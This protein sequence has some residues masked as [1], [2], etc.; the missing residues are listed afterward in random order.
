[1]EKSIKNRLLFNSFFVMLY[2]QF[3]YAIK[4]YS[5]IPYSDGEYLQ[6]TNRFGQKVFHIK[7]ANNKTEQYK[8]E[9]CHRQK[10]KSLSLFE[11][12]LEF[13]LIDVDDYTLLKDKIFDYRNDYVHE[14]CNFVLLGQVSEEEIKIM[15]DLKKISIKAHNRA[16]SFLD[17]IEIS[18]YELVSLSD[19]CMDEMCNIV[20]NEIC[21][22]A[23]K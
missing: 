7:V 4:E 17:D 16:I 14:C 13:G 2:E 19:R 18:D 9:V 8:A 5:K 1:M 22:G 11:W 23:D 6:G 3:L 15:Y 12:A 10:I 20:L 21:K